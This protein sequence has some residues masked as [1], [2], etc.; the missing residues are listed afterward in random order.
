MRVV[1]RP[2]NP[3]VLAYVEALNERF[4]LLPLVAVAD[5]DDYE[6]VVHALEELLD[7]P[8]DK[9]GAFLRV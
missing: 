1:L 3:H 7:D 5:H 4:E 2:E 9:E 8:R 6:V